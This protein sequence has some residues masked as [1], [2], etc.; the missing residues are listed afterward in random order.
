MK[1]Y[2]I[3]HK[4]YQV[5]N[6]KLSEK[7]F[8]KDIYFMAE[9]NSLKLN[10][11]LFDLVEVNYNSNT[12]KNQLLNVFNKHSTADEYLAISIF[13]ISKLILDYNNINEVFEVIKIIRDKCLE[14]NFGYQILTDYYICYENYSYQEE[15]DHGLSTFE[16][17][18]E[19]KDI[20]RKVFDRYTKVK[21]FED[22]LF[23]LKETVSY[24]TNYEEEL[25]YQVKNYI[26]EQS[27]DFRSE[28]NI[29]NDFKGLGFSDYEINE[30]FSKSEEELIKN[31]KEKAL[32][33]L[34]LGIV[35]TFVSV[36]YMYQ[37]DKAFYW[38]I[39]IHVLL[40]PG[41]I[42]SAILLYVKSLKK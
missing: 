6:D 26:I 35:Y 22:W 36:A 10:S 24:T 23:I 1:T 15:I 7:D 37:N 33:L 18:N 19:A 8:E 27:L 21:E 30:N 28:E 9:V 5:L 4:I 12:F 42:Y 39:L 3:K 34:V 14:E 25:S 38:P 17:M 41:L 31:T 11:F 16:L 13:E 20:A 40:G 2:R 29:R 32:P